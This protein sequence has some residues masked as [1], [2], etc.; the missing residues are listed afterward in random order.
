ML[1][2]ERPASTNRKT[3]C[4]LAVSENLVGPRPDRVRRVDT[5]F[6]AF[7]LAGI[8]LTYIRVCCENPEYRSALLIKSFQAGA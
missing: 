8:A 7:F 6:L 4:S 2:F 3:V 5:L 1:L